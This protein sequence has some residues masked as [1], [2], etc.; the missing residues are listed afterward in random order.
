MFD[1]QFKVKLAQL[2]Y[3]SRL[4][5]NYVWIGFLSICIEILIYQG[6]T[7]NGFSNII[8][9]TTG[10]SAGIWI[11]YWLNIRIN[12]KVPRVKRRRAFFYFVT[13]ALFSGLLNFILHLPLLEYGLS[14]EASRFL[15]SGCLFSIGYYLHR[16]FSFSDR[17]QVGVAIYANKVEDIGTIHHKVGHYPDFIHVD[18]IDETF[19]ETALDPHIYR[20]EAI[21]AYWPHKQVHV[22]LMT[23][24]PLRWLDD[25]LPY[26]DVI[27]PHVECDDALDKVFDIIHKARRRAGICL[28][29]DTPLSAIEAYINKCELVQFLA[30]QQPGR[31]GQNFESVVLERIAE[32]DRHPR[33]RALTVCVDGGVNEHTI[34]LLNVE[35]T[36]SGSAVL[37]RA[38]PERQIMR[39]QTSSN[40]E[41]A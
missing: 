27:I 16:R 35:M 7:H 8:A 17:K 33:R 19:G 29:H 38:Q 14:Y 30:I 5:L 9:L 1:S 10:L 37:N 40:Y 41:E 28:L 6:L 24:H 3:S 25:V 31:S 23:R 39:L 20:L 18:I 2:L 22:H 34:Q 11:A 26:C 12:F 36:V 4:L 15:V 32:L 13:I 21:R